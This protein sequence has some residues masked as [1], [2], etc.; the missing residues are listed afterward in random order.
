[1]TASPP[2]AIILV[3]Y[4]T[5]KDGPSRAR[6]LAQRRQEADRLPPLIDV[7]RG[8]LLRY[9]LT[10]GKPA[11]RCHRSP[12]DRHGPYWYVAVSYAGSRQRRY[13]IPAEHVG[14]AR[15]GISIY[16]KV[17]AGL[18]RISEINLELLKLQR[19]G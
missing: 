15:R 11:C 1:L 14:R 18:Y 13:L 19:S 4:M 3:S 7:M 10:C 6:L 2:G 5:R 16:K 12:K 8:T 17:W 9:L